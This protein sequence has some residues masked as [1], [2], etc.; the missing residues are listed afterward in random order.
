MWVLEQIKYNASSIMYKMKFFIKFT[1][2]VIFLF[3]ISISSQEKTWLD[4]DLKETSKSNSVYYKVASNDSKKINFFFR[5]G[6]VYR[7]FSFSDRKID[8]KFS[9][10][11]ESG[12]LKTTGKYEDGFKEGVWKVFYKNGKIKEKGKYKKGEKTGVWKIFYK[13]F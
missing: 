8:G 3:T 12:E 5:N 10:Y 6:K 2:I 7:V 1:S 9:E 11:Y 4:K 13:N